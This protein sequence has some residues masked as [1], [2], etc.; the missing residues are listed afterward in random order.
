VA[1]ALIV[2]TLVVAALQITPT[3]H[4]LVISITGRFVGE[5]IVIGAVVVVA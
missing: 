1:L 3:A 2:L 4:G 5:L